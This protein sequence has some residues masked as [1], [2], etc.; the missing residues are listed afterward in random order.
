M[1][2]EKPEDPVAVSI[3]LLQKFLDA[4]LERLKTKRD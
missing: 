1:S 3:T 2:L 4:G